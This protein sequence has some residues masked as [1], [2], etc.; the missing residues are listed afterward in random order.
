[1]S[2]PVQPQTATPANWWRRI[3]T[4]LNIGWVATLFL[5]LLAAV[6]GYVVWMTES[7]HRS[8][9]Y[10]ESD[11]KGEL[12]RLKNR[13]DAQQGRIDVQQ[14]LIACL[15]KQVRED[16]P[17]YLNPDSYQCVELPELPERSAPPPTR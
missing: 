11:F 13:L 8:N 7:L 15:E 6:G 9:V 5:T 3:L 14:R 17:Y 12:E 16:K 2:V 1:M 4:A 10:I